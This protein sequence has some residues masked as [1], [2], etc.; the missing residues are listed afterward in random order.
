MK[1][2]GISSFTPRCNDTQWEYAP[3]CL[4]C[5]PSLPFITK[6]NKGP[7]KKWLIPGRKGIRG[8][9][10]CL[11]E[12]RKTLKDYGVSVRNRAMM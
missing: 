11:P 6:G 5:D 3:S 7:S 9:G 12:I 4:D 2:I 10:T 1:R 8:S